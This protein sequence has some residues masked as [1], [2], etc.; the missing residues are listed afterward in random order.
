MNMKFDKSCGLV[1]LLA[2]GLMIGCSSH[3]EPDIQLEREVSEIFKDMDRLPSLQDPD[4]IIEDPDYEEIF[5][6]AYS[7][8]LFDDVL[9]G[10]AVPLHLKEVLQALADAVRQE[11]PEVQEKFQKVTLDFLVGIL[12]P[13]NP[14]DPQLEETLRRMLLDEK[15]KPSFPEIPVIEGLEELRA[16]QNE[17]PDGE[18][19][20]FTSSQASSGDGICAHEIYMQF[21][22]G[23]RS[24]TQELAYTSGIIE[25]N[26]IRRSFEAEERFDD[27]NLQIIDFSLDKLPKVVTKFR[28]IL[29][30][31]RESST[32]DEV[33][34]IRSSLGDLAAV[35]AYYLRI[36]VPLWQNYGLSLNEWYYH[37]EMELNEEIRKKKEDEAAVVHQNCIN[38]VNSL[39]IKEVERTCPGDEPILY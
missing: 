20:L 11:S 38:W 1:W 34:E 36:N 18:P 13:R 26:Y 19:N 5:D 17:V 39:I 24:C 10:G 28:R 35:Y 4:P 8:R 23:A 12:D 29:T 37:K 22:S 30:S 7:M 21:G 15:L 33:E 31:I 25:S 2:T 32:T 16:T 14:L 9:E 6:P 3:G 27:R